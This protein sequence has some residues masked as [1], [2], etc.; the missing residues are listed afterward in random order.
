MFVNSPWLSL[1]K[2]EWKPPKL[3]AQCVVHCV[4]LV[5]VLALKLS[6]MFARLCLSMTVESASDF[7]K[8]GTLRGEGGS[9]RNCPHEDSP[10]L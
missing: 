2:E 7:A 6:S 5:G 1:L 4:R 3:V 10:G 9:A 8:R